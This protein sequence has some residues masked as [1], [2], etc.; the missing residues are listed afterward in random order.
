MDGA[1][2]MMDAFSGMSTRQQQQQQQQQHFK[3]TPTTLSTEFLRQ[4]TLGI[5]PE[6]SA[7]LDSPLLPVPLPLPAR[8]IVC[9]HVKKSF[10]IIAHVNFSF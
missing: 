1:K 9:A 5:A 4:K 7:L 10:I 3:L 2:C 8:E 6:H